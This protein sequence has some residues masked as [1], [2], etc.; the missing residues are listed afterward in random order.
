MGLDNKG[1]FF[2]FLDFMRVCR[3]L[4]L[5]SELDSKIKKAQN[6][7]GN[8][9]VLRSEPPCLIRFQLQKG[10]F[11]EKNQFL[12]ERCLVSALGMLAPGEN[13]YFA[14]GDFN[15]NSAG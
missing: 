3:L 6:E 10:L 13:N 11:A 14:P 12:L 7:T 15:Q 9:K 8:E 2:I 4:F 1:C 5:D